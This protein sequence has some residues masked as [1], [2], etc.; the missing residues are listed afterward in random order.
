MEIL[1]LFLLATTGITLIVT[2]S[3]LFQGIRSYV[4]GKYVDGTNAGKKRLGFWRFLCDILGCYMCFSPYAG[5]FCATVIY[6]SQ[7]YP[8]LIYVL[9]PFA[10][11]PLTTL[12]I[13]YY[14]KINRQP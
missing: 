12:A 13:Q 4:T 8:C 1:I 11:V 2:K 5:S 10:G 14:A 7:N 6:F 9:Y 3:L